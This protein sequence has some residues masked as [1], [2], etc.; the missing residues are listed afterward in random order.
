MAEVRQAVIMVGGFGT[1]LLP[2]TKTRPKPAMP[3]LDRPFLKYLI[4]S[5]AEA[6]VTDII[7]ACGYKSDILSKEIGDGSDMDVKIRY[8]DEDEPLGTAGAI[9]NVEKL[10]DPVFVAAN[11]DTL[12]FVDVKSQIDTH[13][14]TGAEVTIS[15]SEIEDPSSSG[16]LVLDGDGFVKQFQEKPKKEEALSNIVNTGLYVMNRDVLR[17]IPE[18]KF[19]DLSKDLFPAMLD[20]G[21]PIGAHT[22]KGIWIDIGKPKDLI[23]MNIVMADELFKNGDWMERTPDSKISGSF[24]IG[25]GSTLSDSES[26]DSI[27]SEG[28]TIRDSRLEDSL[29]M[30]GCK[31]E[32]ATI[33]RSILGEGCTVKKG[34][35]LVDAVI[36]DGSIIG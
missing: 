24:Y 8:M 27:V 35:Q 3:V 29:I 7:L 15:S 33:I 34:A 31:V 13:L 6:G 16:V 5:L 21:A 12:N 19:F 36:E 20:A 9:K 2:L 17:F 23:R 4:D 26:R 30:K 1:R 22:A 11:G 10:L 18:H 32:G 28:C 14:K 25:N